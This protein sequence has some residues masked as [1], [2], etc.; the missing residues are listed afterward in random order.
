MSKKQGAFFPCCP[1]WHTD[2]YMTLDFEENLDDIWNGKVA[3][4]LRKKMYE[5]DFS[6][7]KR[8]ECKIPPLYR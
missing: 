5:G 4:D 3:Q 6:Y 2:E 7:C 8:E 1:S